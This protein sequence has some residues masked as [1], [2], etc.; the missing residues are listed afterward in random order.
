MKEINTIIKKN[1]TEEDNRSD[2]KNEADKIEK[3]SINESN[4]NNIDINAIIRKIKD[5][6]DKQ[7][8]ILDSIEQYK[9][10]TKRII[11][12]KKLKIQSLEAKIEELQEKIRIEKNKKRDKQ[13]IT[14]YQM[15]R[16]NNNDYG[17]E[18][19]RYNYNY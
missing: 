17:D 10:D 8:I 13:G 18:D 5:L 6:S 15:K 4:L 2:R 14:N 11:N 3:K 19:D 1:V 12:Q 9:R 7:I 16:K